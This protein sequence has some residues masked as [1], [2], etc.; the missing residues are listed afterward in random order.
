VAINQRNILGPANPFDDGEKAPSFVDSGDDSLASRHYTA[1]LGPT[2][3]A[4][5]QTERERG[6][7][8]STY[9]QARDTT[10]QFI[11]DGAAGRA[12]G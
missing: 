5:A 3:T 9:E 11:G 6:G 4:S 1:P 7:L 2:D 10:S 8:V 12:I